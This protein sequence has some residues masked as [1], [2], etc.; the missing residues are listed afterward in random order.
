VAS[1]VEVAIP[2]LPINV[3]FVTR[4]N[5][6]Y[7]FLSYKTGVEMLDETK[8]KFDNILICN[9]SFL[10]LDEQK[11]SQAILEIFRRVEDGKL[12]CLTKSK[13]YSTHA[14]SYSFAFRNSEAQSVILDFLRKVTPLDSK[15][16]IIES[17]ELGLSAEALKAGIQIEE[18]FTPSIF[19]K[20]AGTLL[21]IRRKALG[22]VSNPNTYL[23]IWREGRNSNPMHFQLRAVA[24]ALGIAKKEAIF[25]NPFKVRYAEKLK[26]KFSIGK[27][28]P[29][30]FKARLE[31][32]HENLQHSDTVI[33]IHAHYIEEY[34]EI[35]ERLA[36]CDFHFDLVVTTNRESII[37]ELE[38]LKPSKCKSQTILLVENRGRDVLPFLKLLEGNFLS[39]YEVALKIHT[40]RS[41]YSDK[42]RQWF[43]ELLNELLQN[44]QR[45]NEIREALKNKKIGV[46][47]PASSFVGPHYWGSN[48]QEVIGI[49]REYGLPE[50]SEQDLGFF[51]GTMF[52]FNPV[53]LRLDKP[54][55]PQLFAIEVGQQDGTRAHAFERVF[56]EFCANSGFAITTSD[57]PARSV[58]FS[59]AESNRI[60]I[61]SDG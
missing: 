30:Y 11:Y 32:G 55:D 4:P 26:K 29:V 31:M 22:S 16:Q 61:D 36:H 50:R 60:I 14:Q 52:W 27:I 37:L 9:D 5:I 33:V 51:A 38:S 2:S 48:E 42:G 1:P 47:G 17:Y 10:V 13:Q 49:R 59:A 35:L 40:K 19:S 39:N 43:Y 15:D 20:L 54:V 46:I 57:N 25:K 56:L 44:K 24:E 18:I 12:L 6:G 3:E 8:T 23:R 41:T 53:A 28:N 58:G 45:V 21:Y 34:K 7:D